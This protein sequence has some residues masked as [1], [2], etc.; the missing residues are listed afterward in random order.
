M[1]KRK[2]KKSAESRLSKD[3]EELATRYADAFENDPGRPRRI[4]LE[5]QFED[6]RS[7]GMTPEQ[8]QE[9]EP[10]FAAKYEKYLKKHPLPQK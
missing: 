3:L 7:M 9:K 8:L 1:A 10:G 6:C 2:P 5:V 4:P